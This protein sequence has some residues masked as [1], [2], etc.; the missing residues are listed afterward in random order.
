MSG[1]SSPFHAVCFM[2]HT[3]TSTGVS[4]DASLTWQLTLVRTSTVLSAN[5]YPVTSTCLNSSQ[6]DLV[7]SFRNTSTVCVSPA[8]ATMPSG[9]VLPE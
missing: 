7:L 8:G 2:F 9:L 1:M 5:P 6:F 3:V 4:P